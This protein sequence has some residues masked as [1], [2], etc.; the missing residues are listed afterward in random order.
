MKHYT[1]YNAVGEILRAGQ[2]PDEAFELQRAPGEFILEGQSDPAAD[3]VDVEHGVVLPGARP[4]EPIDMDYRRA[5]LDA[6][7]GIHEQMDMLWHA[8]DRQEIA[9]AE[10]FYSRLKAVKDAYPKDN[11]VVPGS[12]LIY[13]MEP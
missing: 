7:P 3:M 1:V 9:R 4:P 11:S 5:R 12:V 10:P 8:M 13:G 2:V 6:Y